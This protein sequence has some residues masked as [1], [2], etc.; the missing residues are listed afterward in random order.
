MLQFDFFPGAPDLASFPRAVWARALRDVLRSAPPSA[1]AYP[2]G[3]GAPALRQALAAYL[4][5]VRG[6]AA[7]PDSIIVCA[8]ATQALALLGRALAHR[9]TRAIAVEDPGLA[10]HRAVL[11]YAGLR[12]RGV[13]VDEHG[14]RVDELDARETPV[15]V[16]TPAH[17]FPTGVA[18]SRERRGAR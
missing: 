2:D 11:A 4:R 17:H 1:F 8:G 7:E 6:V 12:V 5:R 10:P 16:A 3:R 14:L 18:L 15:V 13:G 9:G